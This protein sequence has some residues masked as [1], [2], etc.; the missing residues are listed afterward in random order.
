MVGPERRTQVVYLDGRK[1][2][3]VELVRLG[4][5]LFWIIKNEIPYT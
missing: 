4:Q 3:T 5:D 2:S 1:K